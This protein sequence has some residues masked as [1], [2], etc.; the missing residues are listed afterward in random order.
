MRLFSLWDGYYFIPLGTRLHHSEY[1]PVTDIPRS[2]SPALRAYDLASSVLSSRK[3]ISL[4]GVYKLYILLPWELAARQFYILLA[5]YH[6]LFWNIILIC[7][8]LFIDIN[9]SEYADIV[10]PSANRFTYLRPIFQS[11][12]ACL[13]FGL[14]KSVFWVCVNNISRFAAYNINTKENAILTYVH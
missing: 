10:T 13:F 8:R 4:F 3:V 12:F 6:L 11:G 7:P 1:I 14:K 2:S 9:L 5:F